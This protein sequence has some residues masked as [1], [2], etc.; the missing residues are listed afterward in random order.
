VAYYQGKAQPPE[1]I[2][3]KKK[4]SEMAET[5]WLNTGRRLLQ[6]EIKFIW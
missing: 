1:K 2:P 3:S 6:T 4:L 5:I